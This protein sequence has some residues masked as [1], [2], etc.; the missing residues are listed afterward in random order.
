VEKGVVGG[1]RNE[2]AGSSKTPLC[3]TKERRGGGDVLEKICMR[4]VKEEFT[5][6]FSGWA[7]LTG[8]KIST[9]REKQAKKTKGDP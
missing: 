2:G 8:R 3:P 1:E 9:A 5:F 6:F 7:P 4:G